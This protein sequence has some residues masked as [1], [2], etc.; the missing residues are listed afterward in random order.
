MR[1]FPVYSLCAIV[2]KN[3]ENVNHDGYC[4]SYAGTWATA[5]GYP[6]SEPPTIVPVSADFD[7]GCSRERGLPESPKSAFHLQCFFAL[8]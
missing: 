5:C 7:A 3:T 8:P 4:A 2:D 1:N 6:A